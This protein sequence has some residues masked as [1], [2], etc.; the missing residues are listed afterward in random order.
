MQELGLYQ[1]AGGGVFGA[2]VFIV[3]AGELVCV[4][5]LNGAKMRELR[6][7]WTRSSRFI[8]GKN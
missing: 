4:H 6:R 1:K 8:Y 7:W 3:S 5:A 2:S